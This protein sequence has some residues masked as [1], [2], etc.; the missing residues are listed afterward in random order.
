MHINRQNISDTKILLTITADIDEFKLAKKE[1][2][3]KLSKNIKVAG[4]RQ[5]K[6]PLAVATKHID[7]NVLNNE[8]VDNLVNDLYLKALRE[9][10]LNPI[11]KPEIELKKYVPDNE[12]EINVNIEVI[13]EIKL[14]DYKKLATKQSPGAVTAAEVNDV[15]ERL[16]IQ[17]T[18]Y[19]E[20]QRKAKK[21]DRV[22]INFEGFDNKQ[23]P[24]E[25]AKGDNYPLLLGSN[26]FIPGFEDNLI[27]LGL[28][29]EKSFKIKFPKDYGVK[30]LQSK[31]VEFKVIITKLEEAIA[32]NLD[33][34]FAKKIGNFNTLKELK[35]D[36]K[37][38]LKIEKENQSQRDFQ[39][40]IIKELAKKSKVSIPSSLIDNE[41]TSL[42]NEF[43]QNLL[44]RG[45][46]FQ[47]YLK[48]NDLTEESYK[49]QDLEPAAL[50]R[51]KAGLALSSVAEKEKIIVSPEDLKKRLELLKTQHAK[52]S[53]MLNQ[54][55]TADG[56]RNIVSR[57][58]TEKT[59]T[60]LME[61]NGKK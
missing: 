58:L 50:E 47:D 41:I 55:D 37:K 39:D 6:V 2:L 59:I 32:V 22:W 27:G 10:N 43:K 48:N 3:E 15:I 9:E 60:R 56:R 45:E 49:K 46:S 54:L 35:E 36:I 31:E 20:V 12:F 21:G 61:L 40:Q 8:I 51:L 38:Q 30:A 5:G 16:K 7:V 44:Y 17:S 23:Q 25:G 11:S 24:V 57:M 28:E 26:T 13:G 29:Q 19:K 4:F 33:D 18:E 52:D 42:D 34:D 53:E 1:A 14:P